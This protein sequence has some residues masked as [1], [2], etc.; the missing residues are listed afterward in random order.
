MMEK[1]EINLRLEI[2]YDWASPNTRKDFLESGRRLLL[3]ILESYTVNN[4][5]SVTGFQIDQTI[6]PSI[7]IIDTTRLSCDLFDLEYRIVLLPLDRIDAEQGQ[8]GSNV[9][10]CYFCTGEVPLKNSEVKQRVMSLPM[11]VKRR[12]K[13]DEE[14]VPKLDFE[15]KQSKKVRSV[16]L[17]CDNFALP[18]KYD[19]KGIYNYFLWSLF[20]S[21]IRL[22]EEEIYAMSVNSF[23]KEFVEAMKNDLQNERIYGLL[24]STYKT[25]ENM[26]R[27]TGF[28]PSDDKQS[29][30]YRNE[31]H[32]YIRGM[33]AENETWRGLWRHAINPMDVFDKLLNIEITAHMG[34]IHGDLHPRNIVFSGEMPQ[35]IDFGW[36]IDRAH[37]AKDFILMESNLR[38]VIMRSDT[39]YADIIKL[40]NMVGMDGHFNES[41]I[42]EFNKNSTEITYSLIKIVRSKYKMVAGEN[43]NWLYEYI[44]PLFIVSVGLVKFAHSYSNQVSMIETIQSMAIYISDQLGFSEIAQ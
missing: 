10:T 23:Y 35:I 14:R 38:F 33:D 25:L 31:Y 12:K 42:P 13:E 32:Y 36:A 34:A 6:W 41:E 19:S 22:N 40:A 26:H 28:F 3:E 44:I 30:S 1:D 2:Q 18:F 43:I 37:T 17:S 7:D 11:M 5:S 16:T 8:S 9:M 24:E 20:K 4:S 27:R 21:N 39:P 29:F 15:Y